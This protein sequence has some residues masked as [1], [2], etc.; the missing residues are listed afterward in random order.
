ME[1]AQELFSKDSSFREWIV[2]FDLAGAEYVR[3][4]A[5]LREAFLP[6]ME[7]SMNISIHAGETENVKNIWEAVYYLNADRIGHGLTLNDD[8]KLKSRFLN[9][10]ITIEMCPSSNDQIIGYGRGKKPYPLRDYLEYGLRVTI[11]TDNPGISRTSLSEEYYKAAAIT[12]G[13]L[14]RWE[15]LQLVRNG[16]RGAFLPFEDRQKK[17]LESEKKIIDLLSGMDDE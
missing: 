11:N 13:G 4:P 7:E 6:L 1:L 12:E 17:L 10:K 8:A 2:G 15:V 3:S 16:F 14:S 9:R 5:Q